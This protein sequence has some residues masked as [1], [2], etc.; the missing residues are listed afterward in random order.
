[1]GYKDG[2]RRGD[3]GK[4]VAMAEKARKKPRSAWR[5]LKS[6]SRRTFVLYPL[7][8]I[9]IELVLRGGALVVDPRGLPLLAWGY[10]QYRLVGGYRLKLGGGGPGLDTPPDRIVAEG[11]YRFLRNPMYLGHLI[12]MVGLAISFH[13]WAALILLLVHIPWFHARVL[14]DEAHLE[15]RFGAPYLEYKTRVKRWIPFLV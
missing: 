13:S 1:L 10:L 4:A 5:Y 12:F 7:A 15:E 9:A 8:I 14:K 2:N 6:T 3:G 11:P